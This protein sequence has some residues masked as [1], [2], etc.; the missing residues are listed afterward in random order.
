M[1]ETDLSAIEKQSLIETNKLILVL[2]DSFESKSQ[3]LKQNG[4]LSQTSL[5]NLS[6]DQENLYKIRKNIEK[7]DF[8]VVGY[9]YDR[10][11]GTAIIENVLHSID[12]FYKRNDSQDLSYSS[13]KETN[14]YSK[15]LSSLTEVRLVI[16]TLANETNLSNSQQQKVGTILGQIQG[17]FAVLEKYQKLSESGTIDSSEYQELREQIPELLKI[18]SI[19]DDEHEFQ[20]EF[21]QNIKTKLYSIVQEI[22]NYTSQQ[23]VYEGLKEV[24]IIGSNIEKSNNKFSRLITAGLID[25]EITPEVA[26]EMKSKFD[27]LIYLSGQI[28]DLQGVENRDKLQQLSNDIKAEITMIKNAMDKNK[29]NIKD[30]LWNSLDI[31]VDL[32]DN[33]SSELNIK[34]KQSFSETSSALTIVKDTKKATDTFSKLI[35]LGLISNEILSE[36][37]TELKSKN[38]KLLL[39]ASQIENS[40]EDSNRMKQLSKEFKA[41]LSVMKNIMIENKSNMKDSLWN[42]LNAEVNLLDNL[43]SELNIQIEQN[44]SETTAVDLSEQSLKENINSVLILAKDIK[45]STDTFSKLID[46]GLISN[47]ILSET[48]TELKSKNDKLMLLATQIENSHEDSNRMRQLSNE[49]K[50][51]LSL[52]KN[53]MIENKANMKESLWNSLNAEVTLL[54]NL[55]SKLNIQVEQSISET[56]TVNTSEQS[57]TE[58]KNSVLILAKNIKNSTDRFSRLI[59]LGLSSNEISSEAAKELNDEY[60]KLTQLTNLIEN[61][62]EDPIEMQQL[63]NEIKDKI[64]SMK[65][66]LGENKANMKDTLWN[67]LNT[68]IDQLDNLSSEIDIKIKQIISK[69]TDSVNVTEQTLSEDIYPASIIAKDMKKSTDEFSRLIDLGLIFNDISSDTAEELKSQFDQLILLTNQVKNSDED[70]NRI[71]LSNEFKAKLSLIKNILNVNKSNM[72]ESLW[73]SLS[74][75]VASLENVSSKLEKHIEFEQNS[76][77]IKQQDFFTD[78]KEEVVDINTMLEEVS[79]DTEEDPIK[80]TSLLQMMKDMALTIAELENYKRESKIQGQLDQASLE[81]MKSEIKRLQDLKQNLQSTQFQQGLNVKTVNKVQKITIKNEIVIQNLVKYVTKNTISGKIHRISE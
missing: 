32:L 23:T 37:A 77:Q 9:G 54:D 38:A 8:S 5:D 36:T 39:L 43:S 44:V 72:K 17:S 47:D 35:D 19:L 12:K 69:A 60:E 27:R 14:F 76:S 41:E 21:K 61:S 68:E 1:K 49:F 80:M 66:I 57:L 31:E 65:N 20:N 50:A 42:S 13:N 81:K 78:V 16:K 58:N 53:I 11:M 10:N 30:T 63:S 64:I 40:H 25:N 79:A 6:V 24:N 18:V 59:S 75:E 7:I 70:P 45:T 52:M 3:E 51:E 74:S 67:S 56:T 55:S 46:M 33:L 26:R 34:I 62:H 22:R 71:Q 73:N 4:Y 15:Q 29:V 2:I 28:A 48:A